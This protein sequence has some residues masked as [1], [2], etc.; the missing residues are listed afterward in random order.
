MVEPGRVQVHKW[1]PDGSE[2]AGIADR[3]IA[4]DGA[5]ARKGQPSVPRVVGGVAGRQADRR[6]TWLVHL[7]ALAEHRPLAGHGLSGVD[8]RGSGGADPRWC[9]GDLSRWAA[10]PSPG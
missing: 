5:V 6:S 1:R 3:D 2:P 9:A 8:Q 10:S 7:D 4:M